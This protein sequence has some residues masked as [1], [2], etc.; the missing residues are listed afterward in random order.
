ML[1]P[2]LLLLCSSGRT[3]REGL[4]EI[5]RG[6][7]GGGGRGGGKG[8]NRISEIFANITI[9]RP[10]SAVAIYRLRELLVAVVPTFSVV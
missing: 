7:W 6:G 2:L 3:R 4:G 9:F 1:C 5:F 8:N 10:T